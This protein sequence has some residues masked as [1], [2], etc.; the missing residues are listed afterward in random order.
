MSDGVLDLADDVF[1]IAA[2]V[3][4]RPLEVGH[5]SVRRPEVE[6]PVASSAYDVDGLL[7]STAAYACAA[8][9]A[10][11]SELAGR[12]PAA[13]EIGLDHLAAWCTTLCRVDG[14]PVPAWADISGVYE[15]RDGRHLQVHCNFPH[16][17]EG[18]VRR[19]GVA[20]DRDDVAAAIAEQDVFELETALIADGMIAAVVRTPE[21]WDAHPHRAATIDLPLVSVERLDDAAPRPAPGSVSRTESGSGLRLGSGSGLRLGSGSVSA[22]ATG[23]RSGAGSG[24]AAGSVSG[25]GSAAASVSSGVGSDDAWL[26][27]LRVADCTRVLAGPVAGQLLAGFGAD[28]LRVGAAHLPAVEVG[29]ISTGF[30]KRSAFVDLRTASGS[31]A[32][33]GLLGGADV[34]LDAYRPGALAA[35]GLTPERVAAA[36]PGVV[37]VQ[38]SAFDDLGPWA[39]RRGFDSIVQST[40]G[41]RW[42]GGAFAVDRSGA[43][44]EPVP[45]GLPVQALDYATGFLASGVAA[46]LVARQRREGGSWLAKLS[47]LRTRNALV[48]RRDPTPYEPRPVAVDEAMVGSIDSAFGRVEAVR[49]FAGR[50][51]SAPQRLGTSPAAWR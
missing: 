5:V 51:R 22:E 4:D 33:N 1:G 28:V 49:P 42:T 35:H 45:R 48:A 41:V 6:G 37:I 36:S 20:H 2:L 47:L 25:S 21:E 16:H 10:T 15:G 38:I 23:S 19:L 24:S 39:G 46:Q 32:L 17:A 31:A 18:V 12:T 14:E 9:D 26:A 7:A 11:S 29:V 27:G 43:P 8:V 13:R 40:T 3:D 44:L 50:W 34:W 30:G